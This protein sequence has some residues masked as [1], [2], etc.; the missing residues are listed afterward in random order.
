[1]NNLIEVIFE[2]V[3]VKT[4][5]KFLLDL[6]KAGQRIKNYSWNVEGTLASEIDWQSELAITNTLSKN[7]D[8]AVFINLEIF[9]VGSLRLPQ[10]GIRVL[11]YEDKYDVALHFEWS[12]LGPR[13]H[14]IE[15][16]RRFS[17]TMA[18]QYEIR[19]YFAGPEPA[20]ELD[21]RWFTKPLRTPHT[22]T[23][24][25]PSEPVSLSKVVQVPV[26]AMPMNQVTP[27]VK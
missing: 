20:E 1:M 3:P 21:T 16:L 27:V 26:R 23:L 12:A 15:Q 2:E 7:E 18:N 5:G 19:N 4:L 24:R 14:L 10:V 6:T 13:H 8:W 11:H 9:K 25:N 22:V 17:Q